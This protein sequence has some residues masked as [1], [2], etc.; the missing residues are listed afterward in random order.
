[1]SKKGAE[2]LERALTLPVPERAE[3]VDRLLASLECPAGL[4]ND[5]LWAR[6][7]EERIDAFDRGEIKAVP[8]NE[9]L[10]LGKN[11]KR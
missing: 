6:E 1:L 10:G 8:S 5:A 7:A 11:V 4:N 2:V 9:A 3:L